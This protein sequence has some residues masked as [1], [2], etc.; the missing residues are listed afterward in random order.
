MAAAGD[1]VFLKR[2]L[3]ATLG[4]D[5]SE[6]ELKDAYRSWLSSG[7]SDLILYFESNPPASLKHE[8]WGDVRTR[9]VEPNNLEVVRVHN[10]TTGFGRDHIGWHD[11]K[12]NLDD[13]IANDPQ[14]YRSKIYLPHPAPAY[15]G[16]PITNRDDP[17]YNGGTYMVH[18]KYIE[19]LDKWNADDF[20]F[21]DVYGKVFIGEEAAYVQLVVTATRA[22]SYSAQRRLARAGAER[23]RGKHGLPGFT[24]PPGRGG[25]RDRSPAPFK[26]PSP[27]PLKPGEE[28]VFNIQDTRIRRRGGNT[29]EMDPETEKKIFGLHFISFQNNIQQTGFEFINN[30]W[31]LNPL[32]R[33]VD[34]IL[35][36][37]KGIAEPVEGAYYF[38]PPAHR[39][40]PGEIFFE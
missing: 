31:L 8:F 6:S 39:D 29:I 23:H 24:H 1:D 15:P 37:D 14:Y 17:R 21:T 5:P 18:R 13:A 33:G 12:S 9:V 22:A 35:D 38:V 16:E 2:R 40:Y 10:S 19:N 34:H 20:T 30:I 28:H 11:P 27:P 4:R 7:E 32:F 25:M 26:V 36:P 3:A